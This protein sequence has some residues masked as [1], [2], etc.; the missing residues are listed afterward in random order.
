M[1]TRFQRITP[2]LWFDHQAEEAATFY[3]S[4]FPNSRIVSDT[5]YTAESGQFTGQPAGSVMTVTFEL[6]GQSLTAIN[7][8]PMFKFTEALSLV[9]HCQSQQEVD[10][11]W[12]QLRRG[13]DEQAQQCGWLK[14]RYGLSWQ[15]VPDRLLELIQLP[16]AAKAKRVMDAMMQ[17]K[18][19]DLD[20]LERAA[21]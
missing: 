19:L 18:K 5:R 20:A 14:D 11:Y 10:H 3:V 16:D 12:E 2:F 13:G 17:M 21:A 8:G 1:S 15:V 4:V 6:D 9:V 7:G